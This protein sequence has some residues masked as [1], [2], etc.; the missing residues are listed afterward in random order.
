MREWTMLSGKEAII[1]DFIIS[2]WLV[3]GVVCG[4]AVVERWSWSFRVV[5]IFTCFKAL[6]MS[7]LHTQSA[8]NCLGSVVWAFIP[9]AYAIYAGGSGNE[10]L[11]SNKNCYMY[12]LYK[13]SWLLPI[14]EGGRLFFQ[15]MLQRGE[16]HKS[17]GVF[18]R[19]ILHC[20]VFKGV[21]QVRREGWLL[22]RAKNW[23]VFN[24][25]ISR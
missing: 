6:M 20:A 2:S 8:N 14:N 15:I 22:C 10:Q 9:Y 17:F 4:C 21:E 16:C 5:F 19:I 25:L 23:V 1:N 24:R 3:V 11:C 13:R 18:L 12:T 7:S